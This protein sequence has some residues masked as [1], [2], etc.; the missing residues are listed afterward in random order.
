MTRLAHSTEHIHA[1]TLVKE[2]LSVNDAIAVRTVGGVYDTE[3]E[4]LLL[5]KFA[6]QPR[7]PVVSDNFP[8]ASIELEGI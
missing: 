6:S 2:N 8:Y 4:Y 5:G 3:N 1:V 7:E